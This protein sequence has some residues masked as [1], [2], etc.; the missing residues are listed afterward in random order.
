MHK[1]DLVGE[2]SGQKFQTIPDLE[3]GILG[4]GIM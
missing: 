3:S 1:L 4:E 2:K